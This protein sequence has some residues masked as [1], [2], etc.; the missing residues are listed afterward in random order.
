MPML[1]HYSYM[2]CVHTPGHVYTFTNMFIRYS[3]TSGHVFYYQHFM[4]KQD[5]QGFNSKKLV[6]R[7]LERK[8]KVKAQKQYTCIYILVTFTNMF[9]PYSSAGHDVLSWD[10]G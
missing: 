2:S 1:C 3:S 6:L 5:V 8:N 10:C 4:T 9:I 7:N